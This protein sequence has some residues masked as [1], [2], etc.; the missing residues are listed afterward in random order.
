MNTSCFDD[1]VVLSR[2]DTAGNT[3]RE[4]C[5]GGNQSGEVQFDLSPSIN[6]YILVCSTVKRKRELADRI[7][8]VF[9]AVRCLLKL[10]HL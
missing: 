8:E 3:A 10:P 4:N 9:K 1:F 5:W 7:E 2:P 6:G